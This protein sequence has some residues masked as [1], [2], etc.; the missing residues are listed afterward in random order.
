[1][2]NEEV[3]L[4]HV[5]HDPENVF[6]ETIYRSESSDEKINLLS[7]GEK[8]KSKKGRKARKCTWK[9]STIGNLADCI[10]PNESCKNKLIFTNIKASKNT[11]T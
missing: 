5:D 9:D 3:G 1:M 10:C 4:N 11:K 2:A 6:D 7:K 8:R